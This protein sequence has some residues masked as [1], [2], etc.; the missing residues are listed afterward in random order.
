MNKE[1]AYDSRISPLMTQIIAICKENKIAML[2]TFS[3]P[4]EEDDG[5]VCTTALLDEDFQPPKEFVTALYTI[6]PP[7]RSPLMITT[8]NAN[9][10]VIRMDAIV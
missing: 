6:R 5:C 2:A 3:V 8:R 10:E 4:S 9:G 7:Q 1:Q